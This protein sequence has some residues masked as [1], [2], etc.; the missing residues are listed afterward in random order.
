[1]YKHIPWYVLCIGSRHITSSSRECWESLCV[2]APMIPMNARAD[3]IEIALQALVPRRARGWS[4]DFK[5][6]QVGED[7]LLQLVAHGPRPHGFGY[8][9]LECP[10]H[11]PYAKNNRIKFTSLVAGRGADG[12]PASSSVSTLF[13]DFTSPAGD[14]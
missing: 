11:L 2:P 4:G 14:G 9:S 13:L 7:V 12:R 5:L 1:M 3:R 6:V 10:P 8:H